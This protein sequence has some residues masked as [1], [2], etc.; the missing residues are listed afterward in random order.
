MYEVYDSLSL[1]KWSFDTN[2]YSSLS[3]F[4]GHSKD[5]KGFHENTSG[6]FKGNCIRCIIIIII[7]A[8]I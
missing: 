2:N 6:C 3:Y 8:A 1:R 7:G 4:T 5:K